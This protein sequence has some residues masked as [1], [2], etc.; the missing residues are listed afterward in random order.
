MKF[1]STFLAIIVALFLVLSQAVYTVDQR[2][3][4]VKFQFGEIVST[5]TEPGIAFK[6]PMIQNVRF[7]DKRNMTLTSVNTDNIMTAE[8][9]P[10]L[11]DFVVLWR[12][13][14]VNQYYRSVAGDEEQAKKRLEQTVRAIMTEEINLRS[15]RDVISLERDK[16]T[17]ATREKANIDTKRIGVEIVDV[18]LRRVDFPTEV[19]NSV[20]ERMRAERKRIANELR[21]TGAAES[22]K[23]QAEADRQR[24][25]IIADAYKDAQMIRGK[26]DAEATAIYAKAYNADAEFYNFYRSLEA[27]RETFQGKGDTL[28]LD[29]SSDFFRYFKHFNKDGKEGKP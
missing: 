21:S 28:V 29:P 11:I 1:L 22:E 17:A 23:I 26:G 13:T 4:A 10:L 16:I 12:I 14:D 5:Q 3:Y 25:I 9:K 24:Q 20:Y 6:W 15:I 7:F 27:Y 18:R 2:Q 19:T 8:K